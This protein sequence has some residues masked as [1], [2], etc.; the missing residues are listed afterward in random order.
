MNNKRGGALRRDPSNPILTRADLPDIPPELTDATSV[1]NPGAVKAAG[2]TY[3]VLRVQARSRET[4]MV[5]A[6]SADGVR[7][8]VRPEIVT[9]AALVAVLAILYH[10]RAGRN[11]RWLAV[12]IFRGYRGYLELPIAVSPKAE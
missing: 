7:F 8:V 11:G 10:W 3:L 5:M 9:Y 12:Q 1:F 2:I 4:F 6:E